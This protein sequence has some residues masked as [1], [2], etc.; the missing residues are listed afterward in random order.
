[1]EEFWREGGGRREG[2]REKTRE[3]REKGRVER[4][5][6]GGGRGEERRKEEE[7]KGKGVEERDGRVSGE[8]MACLCR[9]CLCQ[10]LMLYLSDQSRL[11]FSCVPNMGA[12][13]QVDKRATP[14]VAYKDTHTKSC[15]RKPALQN[16][17]LV[18]RRSSSLI[19]FMEVMLTY[20]K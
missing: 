19:S 12:T 8:L 14:A 6:K 17:H 2:G 18:I 1:M 13:A 7:R 3:G 16:R 9:S 5:G 20:L 4:R 15:K 10:C 11:D